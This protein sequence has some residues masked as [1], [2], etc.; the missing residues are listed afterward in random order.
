M[1]GKTYVSAV[2]FLVN[3]IHILYK[4][5][6]QFHCN[7]HVLPQKIVDIQAP[8][9]M[10]FAGCRFVGSRYKRNVSTFPLSLCLY[11]QLRSWPCVPHADVRN[12]V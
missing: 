12:A 5:F 2:M 7:N 9:W 10:Q 1:Y 8:R 4:F 6:C 3:G 11:F